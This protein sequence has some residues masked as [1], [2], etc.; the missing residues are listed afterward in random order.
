MK[1]IGILQPGR[2][3]D[4][5][6]CLPIAKYYYDLGYT[7]YWPIFKNFTKML[8]ERVD[9]VNFLP[10]TND[11]YQCIS[12]AKGAFINY[13][14]EKV[15]DLA[16]TFPGSSVTEEYVKLGDGYGD[17]KFDEFKYR[18]AN[19]PFE[20]KWNLHYKR[21]LIEEENVYNL[22]VKQSNYD[23]ISLKHS[24]GELNVKIE[25]K[26]Q[27]ITLNENH[28]IFDWRKIIENA[29][30]IALVDS[31]MANLVEQLNVDVKKIL[32]MKPGHPGPT[33][34]TNWIIKKV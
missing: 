31:A 8:C 15:L 21:N 13:N 1:S 2:L 32:L 11:V 25:S 33:F 29:S 34:K 19:V 28:N 18:K 30:T 4:I 9:Y 27:V 23:L 26:N 5:I 22:Y 16:A 10:V 3:G 6:I 7:V 24:Q 12:H 17:E 14:V 20:Q